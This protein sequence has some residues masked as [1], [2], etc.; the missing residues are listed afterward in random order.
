M[1]SFN[2]KATSTSIASTNFALS[3]S[4]II[5]FSVYV[6]LFDCDER[7]ICARGIFWVAEQSKCSSRKSLYS[8]ILD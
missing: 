2:M 8:I 4:F 1:F 7:D 6:S 5:F 3:G